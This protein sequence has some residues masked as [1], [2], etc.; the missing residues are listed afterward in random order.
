MS[1]GF[2]TGSSSERSEVRVSKVVHRDVSSR[3]R[4]KRSGLV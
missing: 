3:M 2:V 1:Q 4:A